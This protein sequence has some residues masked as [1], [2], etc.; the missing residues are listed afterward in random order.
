MANPVCD[1]LLTDER[2]KTAGG[3]DGDFGC[4]AVVDF[5]GIGRP[6]EDG[7]EIEG[8]AY[9]AHGAMA[10]HQMRT[11]AQEAVQK[12][13]LAFVALHHRTGFIA[14]GE[15]SLWLRVAAR[16]RGAAFSAS[17]WIVDEL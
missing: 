6:S 14:V 2:L 16:H 8:I 13:G 1:V 4:G 3:V 12:F 10:E 5:Q 7:R 15:T 17:Q 9:E 11:I